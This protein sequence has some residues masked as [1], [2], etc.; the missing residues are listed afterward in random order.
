MPTFMMQLRWT[1]WG[2][3]NIQTA[4]TRRTQGR[5]AA[6]ANSVAVIAIYDTL[7]GPDWIVVGTQAN[8]NALK[9]V[10]DGQATPSVTTTIYPIGDEAGR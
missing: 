2:Y 3:Q 4:P 5:A 6:A 8:V 9:A 7:Q 10:F 1:P